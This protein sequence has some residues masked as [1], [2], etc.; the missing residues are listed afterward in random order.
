M[1]DKD[2]GRQLAEALISEDSAAAEAARQELQRTTP[3]ASDAA[4]RHL[5]RMVN[6]D[7]PTALAV[8]RALADSKAPRFGPAS[9][10]KLF[11]ALAAAA[12]RRGGPGPLAAQASQNVYRRG[13]AGGWLKRIQNARP[14]RPT[15]LPYRVWSVATQIWVWVVFGLPAAFVLWMMWGGAID[16]RYGG[17]GLVGFALVVIAID[18]FKRRCPSCRR[19]LAG[20]LLSIQRTGSYEN[21]HAV[22][23]TSGAVA[24]VG[25]TVHIHGMT[26]RCAFCRRKWST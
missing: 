17:A 13:A 2:K 7:G 25:S 16:A 22:E 18:A 9:W 8:C 5:I 26:W 15:H 11:L 12:E 6:G 23:T 20:D 19:F 4:A 3:R 1:S 14:P 24:H 21:S 10:T